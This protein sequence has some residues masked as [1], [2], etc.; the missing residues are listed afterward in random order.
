MIRII[1]DPQKLFHIIGDCIIFKVTG[2]AK[3]YGYILDSIQNH[4]NLRVVVQNQAVYHW[5]TNLT[6]RYP[7]GY[8]FFERLDSCGALKQQ[9]NIDIPASATN[10]D[11][12]QAKL[13]KIN[14]NG[15]IYPYGGEQ[16]V[17]FPLYR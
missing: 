8:F 12:F 6:T 3:T 11:I 16:N 7:Q 5:L 10:E 15:R 14:R 9:W 13:L 1:N 4:T 2:Y 17:L